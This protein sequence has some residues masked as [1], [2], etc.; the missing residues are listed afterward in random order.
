VLRVGVS[1]RGRFHHNLMLLGNL[2][3]NPSRH[4]IYILFGRGF[5]LLSDV[6]TKGIY[7]LHLVAAKYFLTFRAFPFVLFAANCVQVR[8]C[9]EPIITQNWGG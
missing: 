7:N 4:F 9:H 6:S 3:Q 1:A 5:V 2:S 8:F